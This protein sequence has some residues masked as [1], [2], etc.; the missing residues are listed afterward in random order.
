M[1][2]LFQSKRLREERAPLAVKIKALAEKAPDKLA[3]LADVLRAIQAGGGNIS[4]LPQ[5]RS[6]GGGDPARYGQ[7]LSEDSKVDG[8]A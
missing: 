1:A 2:D 3:L 4:D 6:T 8:R 5:G 7:L